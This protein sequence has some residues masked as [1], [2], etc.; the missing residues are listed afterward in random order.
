MIFVSFLPS[1]WLSC[2]RRRR[3]R[4][5]PPPAVAVV[6][7]IHQSGIIYFYFRPFVFAAA[8]SAYCLL[9]V[10]SAHIGHHRSL[11]NHPILPLLLRHCPPLRNIHTQKEQ[12]QHCHCNNYHLHHNILHNIHT[13]LPQHC[14]FSLTKI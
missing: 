5:C 10:H 14:L 4:R 3:R 7:Q 13:P 11:H 2:L 6:W 12:Q 1:L 9:V 8:A